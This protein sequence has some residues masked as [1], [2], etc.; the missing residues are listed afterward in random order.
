MY[1]DLYSASYD[2][3]IKIEDFDAVFSQKCLKRFCES[4]NSKFLIKE[5]SFFKNLEH[6]SCV[7]LIHTNSAYNF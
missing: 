7:D 2:H 3:F 1:V 6:P 5:P 4:D